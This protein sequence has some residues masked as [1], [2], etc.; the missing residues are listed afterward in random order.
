MLMLVQVKTRCSLFVRTNYR[1]FSYLEILISF[2]LISLTLLA[3]L[4]MTWSQASLLFYSEQNR[5]AHTLVYESIQRLKLNSS[6]LK[7]EQVSP[8]YFNEAKPSAGDC[9]KID[10]HICYQS[11][12]TLAQMAQ[13]DSLELNCRALK[14]KLKLEMLWQAQLDSVLVQAKPQ[15]CESSSCFDVAMKFQLGRR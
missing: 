10:E 4:N 2:A 1:G 12:C 11:F 3:L 13:L 9:K 7:H 8:V 15:S 14:H 5:A 6:F